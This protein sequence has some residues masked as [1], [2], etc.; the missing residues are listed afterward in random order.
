M[1]GDKFFFALGG[2]YIES[3]TLSQALLTKIRTQIPNA[4]KGKAFVRWGIRF[5]RQSPPT[6]LIGGVGRLG[7]SII[8]TINALLIARS[9]G[10][11]SVLFHL[12]E[13]VENTSL[14]LDPHVT[15]RRITLGRRLV[16]KVPQVIWRTNAMIPTGVLC[17]NPCEESLK[18]ARAEL[19]GK[20][21]LPQRVNKS[22]MGSRVLTIHL[23]SGDI[24]ASNPERNYAQPPWAFYER[25]LA[26]KSWSEVR[27]V[28]EDSRSP[29]HPLILNWCATNNIRV[30]ENGKTLDGA[31]KEI[32]DSTSLVL[33]RGTFAPSITF[34]SP[35]TRDIYVFHEEPSSLLCATTNSFFRVKDKE[36]TYVASLMSKNWRNSRRQRALMVNYPLSSLSLVETL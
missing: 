24:F 34:L 10:S 15:A 25:I 28:S 13:A 22:S 21:R 14:R 19:A 17:D 35:V 6:A 30:V 3:T 33:A 27:L 32:V 9:L 26:H 1:R 36:G 2:L 12:F 18:D 20:L 11:H 4:P 5:P 31:I 16:D 29:V 7:N 23:R 8:Q